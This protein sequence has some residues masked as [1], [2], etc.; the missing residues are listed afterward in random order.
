MVSKAREGKFEEGTWGLEFGKAFV[1][2]TQHS[3]P[4]IRNRYLPTPAQLGQ[5]NPTHPSIHIKF[6]YEYM[7]VLTTG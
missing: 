2:V 5:H 1:G 4:Y 7:Q 3:L 6:A